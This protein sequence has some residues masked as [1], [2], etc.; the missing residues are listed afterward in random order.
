MKM[1]HLHLLMVIGIRCEFL[2]RYG[3][4][5]PSGRMVEVSDLLEMAA[6]P[7]LF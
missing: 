6:N 3:L 7:L 4:L 2:S 1:F 5:V